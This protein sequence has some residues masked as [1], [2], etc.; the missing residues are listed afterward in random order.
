MPDI[1]ER[2]REVTMRFLA[3]PTD[4]NF[5]GKVHGGAVMKWIDQAGYAC[6]VGWSGQYCVTVYVGGIRFYRP[7]RIGN[8]VEVRARLAHTGRT[9]MHVVVDVG[10]SDPRDRRRTETTHCVIVFVAVDDEGNPVEVAR[11]R[12]ETEEDAALER[13]AIKL[14]ELRRDME[15]TVADLRGMAPP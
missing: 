11:W 14:M 8:V 12:P 9:S 6:A 7:I 15:G 1:P 10:A 3:Q 13:Y 2:E 4:I 5:G